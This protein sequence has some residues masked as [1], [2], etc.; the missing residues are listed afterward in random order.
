MRNNPKGLDH[1]GLIRRAKLWLRRNGCGLV[2]GEPFRARTT[3]REIPDAIGWR[4]QATSILVECKVSRADFLADAG[5][6]FRQDPDLG[7]GQWR[8]Y[9]CPEGVIQVSDL[10][11]GW[12]LLWAAVRSIIDVHGV[13]GNTLWGNTD[14]APFQSNR[15]AE[16][17]LLSQALRRVQIRGHLDDIYDPV[18]LLSYG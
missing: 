14:A 8:F 2:I 12:G 13:P 4:G 1:D 15:L 6:P 3:S 10:P 9:L 17:E 16:A 18:D 7:L 5:K 11:T